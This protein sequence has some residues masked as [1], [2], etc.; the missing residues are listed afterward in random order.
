MNN[1]DYKGFELVAISNGAKS[2]MSCAEACFANSNCNF[3]TYNSQTTICSLKNV[4]DVIV[5]QRVASQGSICGVIEKRIV[6]DN[7]PSLSLY[8]R[9]W[10]RSNDSSYAW[11][12]TCG[13]RVATKYSDQATVDST[14]ATDCAQQ[15]KTNFLE[16]CTHF[17]FYD[18]TNCALLKVTGPIVVEDYYYA[19]VCGFLT[20]QPFV[21]DADFNNVEFMPN[22]GQNVT[23]TSTA[24]TYTTTAA[25]DD[26]YFIEW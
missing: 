24:A 1:C 21:N 26:F 5:N 20:Q 13:F 18:K 17:H 12:P 3:F 9:Q 11:A 16:R 22:Y 23:A 19:T 2:L 15:C 4:N 25:S 10:Q 8:G 6:I 14:S 7:S